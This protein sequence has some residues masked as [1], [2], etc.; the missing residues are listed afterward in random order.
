MWGSQPKTFS[1]ASINS[2]SNQS[3]PQKPNRSRGISAHGWVLKINKSPFFHINGPQHNLIFR[4]A[5][6]SFCQIKNAQQNQIELVKAVL[7]TLH[8][9]FRMCQFTRSASNSVSFTAPTLRWTSVNT[10]SC[11][12]KG[13]KGWEN[14]HPSGNDLKW[15]HGTTWI[16]H[17]V[18]VKQLNHSPRHMKEALFK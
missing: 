5:T 11:E 15:K 2:V 8:S 9:Y 4:K 12:R 7:K 13:S 10:Y 16:S 17:Y 3:K 18:L 6:N 14:R 1:K